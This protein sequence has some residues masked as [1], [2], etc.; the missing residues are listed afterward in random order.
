[1]LLNN[2][3]SLRHLFSLITLVGVFTALV[4]CSSTDGTD[5]PQSQHTYEYEAGPE[6]KVIEVKDNSPIHGLKIVVPEGALAETTKIT[7][8]RWVYAPELPDGLE[9]NYYFFPE[10][11]ITSDAPFLKEIQLIFP[12]P[13]TPESSG[14]ILCAFYWDTDRG[15]WQVVIPESFANN[16][17]KVQTTHFSYWQFG[18]LIPDDVEV[19]TIET[20]LDELFGPNFL[21]RLADALEGETQ[22]FIDWSI[23]TYCANQSDIANALEVIRADAKLSAEGYLQSV[24]E[25]CNIW[26][27]APTVGDIFYGIEE[28]ID[29]HLQYLGQTIGAEG[30]SMVP[31]IGDILAIVAKASAQAVYEQN[32][33]NLKDEYMCIFEEAEYELWINF[34]LYISAD[35]ALL[36]MEL[37]ENEYPCN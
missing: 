36:G 26:D 22:Q 5:W 15:S 37:I 2:L 32:L 1:M 29:I 34:G 16:E 14:K 6:G 35:A 17:M 25:I 7:I 30:L 19:E 12:C 24:N 18:E 4:G 10:I 21:D 27:H 20:W 9:R 11:E 23:W 31:Y 8:N 28:L 3:K 13:E 33:N